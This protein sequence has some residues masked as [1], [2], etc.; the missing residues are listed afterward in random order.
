MESS[1]LISDWNQEQTHQDELPFRYLLTPWVS[2][3]GDILIRR[4]CVKFV[5]VWCLHSKS[6]IQ[7]DL[8]SLSWK[9]C[10]LFCCSYQWGICFSV[11]RLN[12]VLGFFSSR[13]NW[14]PPP[15]HPQASVSPALWFRGGGGV[16]HSLAGEGWVG[17]PQLAG[18]HR[19]CGTLSIYFGFYSCQDLRMR[20]PQNSGE[21]MTG[22]DAHIDSTWVAK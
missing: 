17:G 14:D 11:Y 6:F 3:R 21:N 22:H 5:A 19:H 12:R 7:F 20:N 13:W 2:C 18:E 8:K 10:T 15:P 9:F 4:F 1:S 16:T